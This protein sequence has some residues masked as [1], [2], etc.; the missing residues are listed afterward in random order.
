MEF[1]KIAIDQDVVKQHKKPTDIYA[2]S[3]IR[4]L[5]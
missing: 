2:V 1:F 5:T 3:G 4:S